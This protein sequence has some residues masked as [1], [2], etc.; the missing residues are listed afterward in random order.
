M[1]VGAKRAGRVRKVLH[2]IGDRVEP[3]ETARR[4]R[5]RSTPTSASSR[6]RP[7]TSA[8]S[9]SSASRASRPRTSSPSSASASRS[10]VGE[11]VEKRIRDV[12]AVVQAQL[13]LERAQTNLA[14]EKLLAGR[15]AGTVQDFQNAENDDAAAEAALDNAILTARVDP[16]QRHGRAR[17]RSTSPSRPSPT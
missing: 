1:T 13:A 15:N 14:R 3:G 10:C 16:G 5:G 2:D 4:A 11:E 9:P 6:P 17:S 8:S 12:P 7:A